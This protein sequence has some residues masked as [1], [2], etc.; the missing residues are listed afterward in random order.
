MAAMNTTHRVT[1]VDASCWCRP[2]VCA[3]AAFQHQSADAGLLDL[4]AQWQKA[5]ER[6]VSGFQCCTDTCCPR[7][8]T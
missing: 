7:T 8:E 1:L 4:F 6:Y 2:P 5:K 3:S